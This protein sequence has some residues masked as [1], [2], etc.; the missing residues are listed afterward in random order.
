MRVAKTVPIGLQ[1]IDDIANSTEDWFT[2]VDKILTADY[3]ES[4]KFQSTLLFQ[5]IGK[6]CGADRI[7][8]EFGV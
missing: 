1:T 3:L 7:S 5:G 4:M 8:E 6:S 2:L